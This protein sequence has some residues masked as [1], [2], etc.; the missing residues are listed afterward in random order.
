MKRCINC[1]KSKHSSKTCIMPITSYGIIHIMNE[2][3]LMICRRKT[4]GFT[5]FIRGKYSF[6]HLKN[7]NNLIHEMTLT[8][9]KNI[10]EQDFNTLWCDLWGISS[11]HSMDE[12]HARDK[13]N[14]IKKG[15]MVD[16]QFICLNDLIES[17]TSTWE[18]PE[19]G[20]PKGRRNPYETELS[21]ALREYEEETGYDKHN[22]Q[23]IENILPYEE[24]FMGSNYKS[25]THKYYIGFSTSIIAKHKF[26]ES[27]VSDMKWVSYDEAIAMIRPYN[28]ERI[29][30]LQYVHS[31][32]ASYTLFK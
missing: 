13:F 15:Y 20:F 7:I 30:L 17:S 26:Q 9:K 4:L 11:D 2:K 23:L 22:L 24:I 3:Y 5:D 32:L 16:N 21:C 28:I 29:Q 25:Y 19:W 14:M 6:Q 31:C 1:N 8:E 10:L 18:T 27:E 12:L